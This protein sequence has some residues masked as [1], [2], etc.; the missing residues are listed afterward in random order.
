MC[1]N[2]KCVKT[3]A[4]LT[5]E[6]Q[7]NT[8][9]LT[10]GKYG[11]LWPR[12]TARVLLGKKTVTLLPWNIYLVNN[13][14]PNIR[15]LLNKA[16]EK[17]KGSVRAECSAQAA[18]QFCP[19]STDKYKLQVSVTITSGN[20]SLTLETNEAYSMKLSTQGTVI[21]ANIQARTFFGARHG[22]ETLSQ[23]ISYD[24]TTNALQMISDAEISDSPKF[25]Y[26][27][28]LLDTSRNFYSVKR[29]LRLLDGMAHSKLN[30]FHWHITDTHSFPIYTP[31]QPNMTKYGAYSSKQ[32]Y[33]PDNVREIVEY[34]RIRG[35]RVMPEFDMPAH[36]GNGWQWGKKAGKG[37]LAFC[38]NQEP[39][40]EYCLEPPCGQLNP[41][42]NHT[43]EVLFNIFKDYLGMFESEL[44]HVGGD[45][46]HINCWNTSNE[47]IQYLAKKGKSRTEED[48]LD[49]MGDFLDRAVKKLTEANKGKEK[50]LMIWSSSIT[51][52]KHLGKYIDKDKYI[53]QYWDTAT[54]T[55]IKDIVNKG[56]RIV[57]SN[58][59]R[60]YLDC[61]FSNWV[62]DGNNWC[63]PYK[64]WQLFYD[65]NPFVILKNLNVTLNDSG[66]MDL[67][68]GGES[69]MWSEQVSQLL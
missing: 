57:F 28:V 61:G 40:N 23:L 13:V 8:C 12:P 6:T 68:L 49:L 52:E 63:S 27:G 51:E 2:D 20:T 43:Y 14:V 67:V 42:N 31:S 64:G 56:F 45:E 4:A 35:I 55:M 50:L 24:E 46:V 19:A 47:I 36:C 9:K 48:F 22:L 18:K 41:I 15:I 60:L 1:K 17:F 16:F 59:D 37:D 5:R 3:E 44:F 34:A 29:I 26:R 10:C 53:I 69:A 21:K 66:K 65:N 54:N 30:T 39:W 7:I 58:Y 33:T 62:T 38:V 25:K 32:I 11:P